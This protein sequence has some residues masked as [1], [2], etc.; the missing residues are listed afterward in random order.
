MA[1]VFLEGWSVANTNPNGEHSI[2]RG[3]GHRGMSIRT[4][5]PISPKHNSLM[6]LDFFASCDTG[7]LKYHQKQPTKNN[8]DNRQ[9]LTIL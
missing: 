4:F 8:I 2:Y 1:V 5:R 6:N 7:R 9:T 3:P